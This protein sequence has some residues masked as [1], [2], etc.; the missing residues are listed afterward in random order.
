MRGYSTQIKRTRNVISRLRKRIASGRIPLAERSWR[1]AHV[2]ISERRSLRQCRAAS[3]GSMA[4]IA[5]S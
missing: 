3:N 2:V 4:R 1:G 5:R